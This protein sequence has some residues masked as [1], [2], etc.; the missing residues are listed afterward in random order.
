MYLEGFES[1]EATRPDVPVE[2]GL[3]PAST[4]RST[5]AAEPVKGGLTQTAQRNSGTATWR[6]I[7]VVG[8]KA[9]GSSSSFESLVAEGASVPLQGWDFSWFEG[10]ATEE[11]P[12]WGYAKMV[13]RRLGR[14]RAALDVD[15][16]GGEVL[17]WAL[18]HASA[19]P[20]VLA[21]VE[22]WAANVEVARRLGDFGVRIAYVSANAPLPFDD[23]SFD[24][25]VSRHP[26]RTDWGEVARVLRPGGSYLSQQ[27]GA[28]S[29]KELTDFLMGH[30]PVGGARKTTT[31][32]TGAEGAGLKVRDLREATLRVVF[33][34]IGAVVHFLRKVTWT[35]P[36]F[37]VEPYRDQLVALHRMIERS[38]SFVCHSTR[39][40]IEATKPVTA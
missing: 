23:G 30:Q 13:S 29:N 39:F 22:G 10:R 12:P 8:W 36:D 25:V 16:G 18:A 15:T 38:G 32:I 6:G 24:L 9:V 3:P 20:P 37:S 14:A 17:A 28:G 33:F 1:C 19:R 34:D 7:A 27:V 11:R 5:T 40:L 35:V 4:P 26:V 2:G 31:V 21:A